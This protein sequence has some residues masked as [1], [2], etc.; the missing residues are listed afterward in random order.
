MPKTLMQSMV[1]Q[2]Q[3]ERMRLENELRR[4][5]A[6][7]T[8]FGKVYLQGLDTGTPSP[9]KKRTAANTKRKSKAPGRAKSRGRTAQPKRRSTK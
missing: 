2:L 7:L 4:V 9:A 8:A 5:T 6:A 3:K 1:D